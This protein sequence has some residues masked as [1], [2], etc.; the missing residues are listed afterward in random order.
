M[1]WLS[2]FASAPAILDPRSQPY[3]TAVVVIL[4]I[5]FGGAVLKWAGSLA[6]QVQRALR[7]RIAPVRS[8]PAGPSPGAIEPMSVSEFLEI[9]TF[10][11]VTDYSGDRR[12]TGLVSNG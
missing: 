11:S 3:A 1:T 9:L 10:R 7:R 4:A 8:R 6:A 12:H 5:M 2:V